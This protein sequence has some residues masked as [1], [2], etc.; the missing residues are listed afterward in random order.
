MGS[1]TPMLDQALEVLGEEAPRGDGG[2]RGH[3]S[4]GDLALAETHHHEPPPPPPPPPRR[5]GGGGGGGGAVGTGGGRSCAPADKLDKAYFRYDADR[6]EYVRPLGTVLL[7]WRLTPGSRP[8]EPELK[9]YRVHQHRLPRAIAVFAPMSA[10]GARC[11]TRD[12]DAL[13]RQAASSA[14]GERA[15]GGVQRAQGAGRAGVRAVSGTTGSGA[16]G[17]G[18]EL[19]RAQWSLVCTAPTCAPH[20]RWVRGESTPLR[21]PEGLSPA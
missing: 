13:D 7:P 1:T 20:R 6:D 17:W 9:V 14:S 21:R 15:T 10:S 5:R 11:T 2:G 3:M 12:R 4:R 19:V 16:H 8:N 18:V